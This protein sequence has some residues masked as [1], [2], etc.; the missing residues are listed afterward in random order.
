[1]RPGLRTTPIATLA[2]LALAVSSAAAG[3]SD[4]QTIRVTSVTV[5]LVTHDVAPKG[6]SKGDTVTYR[7]KLL[8]ATAAQFGKSK[9]TRVGSDSGKL[10][11]TSA[12]T[13]VFDGEASLPGGTLTLRGNV[14]GLRDGG[15]V[16]PVTGGTGT[17]AHMTGTL[18]VG[19]GSQNVPNTYHLTRSNLPVA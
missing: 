9:G 11:F 7:D 5:K 2:V 13:A 12:N 10:T 17:F 19:A 15:L 3:G 8:N 18:T 1:M 14:I 6:A 4:T 16:I